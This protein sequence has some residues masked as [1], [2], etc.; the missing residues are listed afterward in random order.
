[1]KKKVLFLLFLLI[2]FACNPKKKNEF[3]VKS[4]LKIL[5]PENYL[6]KDF[7][8]KTLRDFEDAFQCKIESDNFIDEH[9]LFDS[10]K[11]RQADLILEINNSLLIPALRES[12]LISY[13]PTGI[14]QVEKKYIFDES[15]HLIPYDFSY[16]TFTFDEEE[17]NFEPQTFGEMQDGKWNNQIIV[18]NP[19]K[20]GIVNAMF[21]WS[22]A[23]FNG[24]GFGHFWRSIKNNL[25]A[26]TSNQQEAYDLF[27]AGEA[28]IVL[29][30]SGFNK[31][32]HDFY[33][34]K[35]YHSFIPE[36]GGF[37]LIEAVGILKTTQNRK[38]AEQFVEYLLTEELQKR[39]LQKKYKYPVNKNL[40]FELTLSPETDVTNNLSF[41]E[42]DE[43]Y[44]N[45]LRR[46]KRIMK[47]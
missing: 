10:A 41:K 28:P 21:L 22:V 20:C 36:E 42:I 6:A 34:N 14:Y 37:L 38:L 30:E 1:M 27:L 40:N 16:L 25:F 17:I 46:W 35:K 45:W 18:S 11:V 7:L 32:L 31:Y 44:F 9:V 43:N 12:I 5:M 15:Y 19:L 23:A 3:Q 8:D 26:L 33:P 13:K 39:I 4:H 2:L 24:N 47:K 29:S